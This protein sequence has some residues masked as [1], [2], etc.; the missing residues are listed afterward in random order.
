MKPKTFTYNQIISFFIENGLPLTEKQ[1]HLIASKV[2]AEMILLE[3][4]RAIEKEKMD[5][6]FLR[7]QKKKQNRISVR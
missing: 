4:A 1:V 5:A 7:R 2:K 3:K 6:A